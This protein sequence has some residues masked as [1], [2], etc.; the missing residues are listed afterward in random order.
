MTTYNIMR[1]HSSDTVA[2]VF[3]T[4][5]GTKRDAK[6]F[7]QNEIDKIHTQC[8]YSPHTLENIEPVYNI[9][10]CGHS[11]NPFLYPKDND[12]SISF[13]YEKVA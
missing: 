9:R 12:Y 7:C 13:W 1:K 10:F 8:R 5:Q 11:F 2:T 4:I 6:K 3:E